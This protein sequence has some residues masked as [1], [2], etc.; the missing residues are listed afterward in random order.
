MKKGLAFPALALAFLALAFLALAFLALAFLALAFPALALAQESQPPPGPAFL[1]APIDN[2]ISDNIKQPAP[3]EPAFLGNGPGFKDLAWSGVALGLVL[4]ALVLVLKAVKRIGRFKPGRGALFEMRGYQPLDNRK[5]LA[6]VAVDG[7]MLIIGVTPDRL[8][9][10]GQWPL[11]DEG[12][13]PP[14]GPD[15]EFRPPPSAGPEEPRP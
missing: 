9:P 1:G 2:P 14:D 3:P 10:L 11:Q 6:A 13:F 7:R 5:Y 8:V 15:F 4:A 12:L